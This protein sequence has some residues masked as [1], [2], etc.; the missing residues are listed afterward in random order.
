[1]LHS[2]SFCVYNV[3]NDIYD[4]KILT[5]VI[6]I[7]TA[8]FWARLDAQIVMSN[9]MFRGTSFRVKA[10]VLDSLTKDPITFASAYLRHPK[11]TVITNFALTDTLG[12]VTIKDVAKGEH[13]L[14]I[15]YL[16]YKPVYKKI[17]VRDN[18]D[19]K[20]I[21]MRPDEKMLKAASVTAAASPMEIRQDTVIY[22]AAAF[23]VMSTDNLADLLKKMP[24]VEV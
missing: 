9:D 5:V 23:N 18:Y 13:L 12:K 8:L 14:C 15:E 22:N 4:K 2:G 20:V 19:A 10:Q 21:L 3:V 17:Y 7:L 16:G 24:G 11:D 1:M 6:L